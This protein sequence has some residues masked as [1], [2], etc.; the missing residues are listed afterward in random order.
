MVV[1]FF[2]EVLNEILRRSNRERQEFGDI[3]SARRRKMRT[4][5]RWEYL[6][7]GEHLIIL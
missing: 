6:K 4:G 3:L 1:E 2:A 7:K 5:M